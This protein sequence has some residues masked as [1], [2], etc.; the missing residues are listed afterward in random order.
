MMLKKTL[1]Y[2]KK[3]KKQKKEKKVEK[4]KK[5]KKE[6]GVKVYNRGLHSSYSLRALYF[7]VYLYLAL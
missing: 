4:R 3:D 5:K 1:K 6:K 2:K 7:S